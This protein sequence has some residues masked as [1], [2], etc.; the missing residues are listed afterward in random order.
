[1]KSSLI[2]LDASGAEVEL[3]L[4]FTAKGTIYVVGAEGQASIKVKLIFK[5]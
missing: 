1:M 3:S 2:G 4:G 5:K